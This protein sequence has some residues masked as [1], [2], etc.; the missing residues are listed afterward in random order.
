MVVSTQLGYSSRKFPHAHASFVV[1]R[2]S[3][4]ASTFAALFFTAVQSDACETAVAVSKLGAVLVNVSS[5]IIFGYR[6]C[7]M[8]GG[9]QTIN[10]IVGFMYLVMISSWVRLRSNYLSLTADTATNPGGRMLTVSS[11]ERSNAACWIQL[12]NPSSRIMGPGLLCRFL[13]I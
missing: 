5:G 6:G 2:Y 12:S 1:L 10:L 11:C 3:G 9:N 8:W 7:A 13:R 4:F